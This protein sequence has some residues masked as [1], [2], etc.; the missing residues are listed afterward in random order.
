MR[1]GYGVGLW[2]KIRK[3]G[4][5]FSN[6]IVFLVSDARRVRFWKDKWCRD[7]ALCVSFPSM[8]ALVISKEA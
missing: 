8:Y 4:D 7:V 3:E 1:E 6:R 2:K 5:L